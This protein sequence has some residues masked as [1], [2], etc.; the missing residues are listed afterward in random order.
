ML[1]EAGHKP[2]VPEVIDYE[3]RRELLR[4][5]KNSS[6]RKLDVLCET[7]GYIPI[8]TQAMRVAADFWAQLRQQRMQTA[9]DLSLDADVI[10]AAQAA[11]LD[12]T[13]WEMPG[14]SVVIATG[15]VGH[16]SRLA[17]TQEWPTIS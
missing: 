6:V 14:A 12:P 7:L 1:I 13:A 10:L 2:L 5:G 17:P 8:T 16:L 11:P 3:L 9:P 4:A 15:N